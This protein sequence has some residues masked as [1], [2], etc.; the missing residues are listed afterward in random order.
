MNTRLN[1]IELNEVVSSDKVE[2]MSLDA[3]RKLKTELDSSCT[4][5]TYQFNT[6]GICKVSTLS[7]QYGTKNEYAEVVNDFEVK[8]GLSECKID[9]IAD[10]ELSAFV[11]KGTHYNSTTDFIDIESTIFSDNFEHD[12]HHIDMERAYAN[13][14]HATYMRDSWAK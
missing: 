9:D 12:I 5:Y 4:Y 13:F 11:K 14:K 6:N 2:T 8:S 3:L 7:A 1:H 10:F